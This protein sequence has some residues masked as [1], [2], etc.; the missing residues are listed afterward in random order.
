ML[1]G[2]GA[3]RVAIVGGVRIPFARAHG[4]YR[5]VGNSEMLQTVL[6][7][8]VERFGLRGQRLGE[9]AAG[10]MI[11]HPS[12][13]NLTREAVFGSGLAAETPGLD[14]QRACG[15]SLEAAIT[16]ANKIALGQIDSGIAAGVDSVSDPPVMH[17]RGFRQLLLASYRGETAGSRWR[18]W[19]ALRPRHL[20]P[21][22]PG[23]S[24][25]QTG[26][27]LG[28]S[29]ERLAT[30][31]GITRDDQDGYA[32]DSHGRACR[33]YESGFYRELVRAHL[34]VEQD[35]GLRPNLDRGQLAGLPS[36]FTAAGGT[37]TAGNSAPA[38]DGAAAVLLAS[39]SWAR[40][41]D[42]PVLAF[43]RHGKTA[44]V[45][46]AEHAEDVLMA[47]A[48]VVSQLLADMQLSLQDFDYYEMHEAF[49]AQVL[50]TLEAWSDV[51]FCR[52]RLGLTAPL[53]RV[54]RARLNVKGGSLAFGSPNAATGARLLATLAQTLDEARAQRGLIAVCTAGGMGVGAIL[55]R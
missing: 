8:L 6:R 22:L 1:V 32:L 14:L 48:Y 18:P 55:E 47:P 36:A 10:A 49:A 40:E 24:E 42:L 29:T 45:D 9:V 25:P 35:D 15:T 13:W 54:D 20:R 7:A 28:A 12:E 44:A 23:L 38:A 27:S 46:F 43:L 34:G 17:S 11:K 2:S 30:R 21:V 41:R 16:L 50:S 19:L 52:D 37:L 33:A 5:E 39:E 26:L 53:G 3:R 31:W 51:A 4:A